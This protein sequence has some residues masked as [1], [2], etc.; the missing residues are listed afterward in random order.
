MEEVK[1]DRGFTNLI[2]E[3][4]GYA[5]VLHANASAEGEAQ[6]EPGMKCRP[7][8]KG[9]FRTAIYIALN[10]FTLGIVGLLS[11]WFPLGEQ[12]RNFAYSF[13]L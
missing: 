13:S 8:R 2:E 10:I 3:S 9:T 12:G 6:F 5:H 1:D 4:T 7:C 11:K